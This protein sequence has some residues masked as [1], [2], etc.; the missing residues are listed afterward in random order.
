[1]NEPLLFA[2]EGVRPGR[3]VGLRLSLIGRFDAAAAEQIKQLLLHS[4]GPLVVDFSHLDEVSAAG[5][6]R[7]AVGVEGA[8]SPGAVKLVGLTRHQ[9]RLLQYFGVHASLAEEIFPADE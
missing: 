2:A 9:R 1:M 7:L 8:S 5:L 6:Q 3:E 4:E